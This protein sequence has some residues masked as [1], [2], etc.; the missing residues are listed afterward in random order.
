MAAM[1]PDELREFLLSTPRTAKLATVRR[2]GRPHVAPVWFDLDTDGTWVFMTGRKT[3]KGQ[4]LLR[5]PRACLCVDDDQPPYSFV[6]VD[7]TATLSE[8]LEEMLGW[9]IRIAGRYLG[10]DKAESFGRRNAVPGE[11]L[12]RVTPTKV[13]AQKAIAD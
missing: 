9:S 10:A 3:A 8:D 5:D 2:D 1:T 6:I 4:A 12:V 13:V 11:L 7:G